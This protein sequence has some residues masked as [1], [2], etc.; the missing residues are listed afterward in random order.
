MRVVSLEKVKSKL[1][2]KDYLKVP[3][4][5]QILRTTPEYIYILLK[6]GELVGYKVGSEWRIPSSA[7]IKLLEEW[8]LPDF[9]NT[10]EGRSKRTGRKERKS[11]EI[12]WISFL[13]GVWLGITICSLIL[14]LTLLR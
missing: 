5:A 10:N 2:G 4:V 6:N 13:L 8:N 1:E 12:D 9:N 11:I 3:E 14:Y 7:I